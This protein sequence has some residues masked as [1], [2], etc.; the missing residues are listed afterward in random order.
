M[1]HTVHAKLHILHK[2]R[3]GLI[4]SSKSYVNW[5]LILSDLL[6]LKFFL[7]D[8]RKSQVCTNKKQTKTILKFNTAHSLGQKQPDL[9]IRDLGN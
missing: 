5:P 7:W 1:W 6:S 2:L 8:F 4:I 9:C 3:E